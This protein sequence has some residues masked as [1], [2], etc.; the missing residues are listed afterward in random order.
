[1]YRQRIS[2]LA[3][4]CGFCGL[5]STSKRM[6]CT[7]SSWS[8][9][10]SIAWLLVGVSDSGSEGCSVDVKNISG[11]DNEYKKNI[12][13]RRMTSLPPSCLGTRSRPSRRHHTQ[14][15]RFSVLGRPVLIMAVC[16][17][18]LDPITPNIHRLS[19]TNSSVTRDKY[20]PRPPGA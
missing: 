5:D 6:F 1:M 13:Q 11:Q 7:P 20:I 9:L 3:C 12:R 19:H 2:G 18:P 16:V 4:F 14:A 15:S 10:Y 8:A 17:D